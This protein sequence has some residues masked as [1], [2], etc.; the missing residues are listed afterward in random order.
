[1][2]GL[3]GKMRLASMTQ[4]TSTEAETVED[5]PEVVQRVQTAL[6]EIRKQFAGGEREDKNVPSAVLPGPEDDQSVVLRRHLNTYLDMMSQRSLFL[7]NVDANRIE[8][9]GESI[10]RYRSDFA[11]LD[12]YKG[13]KLV[14]GSSGQ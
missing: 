6:D 12:R 11:V 1:M 2:G 13:H 10:A 5:R 4:L 3:V 9:R 8:H 14:S 7:G